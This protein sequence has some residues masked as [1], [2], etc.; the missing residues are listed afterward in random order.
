MATTMAL[1]DPTRCGTQRAKLSQTSTPLLLSRRSTCLI[2]CLVTRPRACAKAWPIMATAS[3]APVMTPPSRAQSPNVAA[4]SE[5][6]R[7]A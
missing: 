7:L 5:S 3:E 1:R 4:A 6:T 2:A